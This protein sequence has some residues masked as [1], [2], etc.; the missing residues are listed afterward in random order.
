MEKYEDMNQY[1]IEIETTKDEIE[2]IF[3]KLRFVKKKGVLDV[4]VFPTI[5]I[6]HVKNKKKIQR[7]KFYLE[8]QEEIPE[9]IKRILNE[10]GIGLDKIKKM[11]KNR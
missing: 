11:K 4:D 9:D 3:N 10:H 5:D 6:P 1:E 7:I 8:K 2:T